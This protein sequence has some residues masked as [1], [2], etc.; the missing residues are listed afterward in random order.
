MWL[1]VS[2]TPFVEETIPS[3][4]LSWQPHRESF[5]HI[6]EAC[7]WLSFYPMVSMSV[8]KPA[9][10]CFHYCG[11]MVG[12]E[13]RTRK[14]PIFVLP[15][16]RFWG[17]SRLHVNLKMGFPVSA[18]HNVVRMLRELALSLHFYKC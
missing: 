9:S 6:R 10:H 18:K 7:F 17:P 15:Q 4:V 16:D 13:I 14:P 2:L 3:M 5:D 11:F 12:F 1:P 8:F